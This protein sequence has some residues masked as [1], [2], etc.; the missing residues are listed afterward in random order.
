MPS[1]RTIRLA[2]LM[3]LL[4]YNYVVK[5]HHPHTTQVISIPGTYT[6]TPVHA[7]VIPK[8]FPS[9]LISCSRT[10]MFVGLQ[11]NNNMC[12]RCGS[13]CLQ[14]SSVV[15]AVWA[16]CKSNVVLANRWSLWCLDGKCFGST[17][18]VDGRIGQIAVHPQKRNQFAI[19]SGVTDFIYVI[20]PSHELGGGWFCKALSPKLI[21]FI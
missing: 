9:L 18:I 6:D 1:L 5:S 4:V 3:P 19:L 13:Y 8:L 20:E 14:I 2:Y 21:N 15:A 12:S 17:F 7:E 16:L 10:G 11:H